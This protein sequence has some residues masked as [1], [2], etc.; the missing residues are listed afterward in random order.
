MLVL[1][2]IGGIAAI[3][4]CVVIASFCIGML[5]YLWPALLGVGGGIA[6]IV[7]GYDNLGVILILVGIFGQ[8]CWSAVITGLSM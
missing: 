6:A 7:Q 4:V 5:I 2:I 3:V 1:K 8:L